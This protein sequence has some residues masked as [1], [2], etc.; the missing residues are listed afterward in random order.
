MRSW[1]TRRQKKK[2]AL[3]RSY[4][5][6]SWLVSWSDNSRRS[7]PG[8]QPPFDERLPTLSAATDERMA[9]SLCLSLCRGCCQTLPQHSLI[10]SV[11]EPLSGIRL[12]TSCTSKTL[13]YSV[14]PSELVSSPCGYSLQIFTTKMFS[15]PSCWGPFKVC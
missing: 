11:I 3:Q 5:S 8:S 9:G 2:V 15:Q 1:R 10:L 6:V 13:H 14:S 4:H 12:Q 7:Q